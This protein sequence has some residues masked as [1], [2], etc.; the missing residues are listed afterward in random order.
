MKK[1][2][3]KKKKELKAFSYL[4]ISSL[5]AGGDFPNISLCGKTKSLAMFGTNYKYVT[6]LST[7]L[8]RKNIAPLR[9]FPDVKPQFFLILFFVRVAVPILSIWNMRIL[10]MEGKPKKY[11]SENKEIQIIWLKMLIQH[12]TFIELVIYQTVMLH[13]V[14]RMRKQTLPFSKLKLHVPNFYYIFC[15]YVT[16]SLFSKYLNQNL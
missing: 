2:R 8:H 3:K 1:K 14:A 10:L 4:L 13:L 5:M 11:S 16:T 7:S 12:I 15:E 6:K 9:G